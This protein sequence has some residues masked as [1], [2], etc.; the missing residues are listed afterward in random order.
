MRVPPRAVG[1]ALARCWCR[2]GRRVA[3]P[4]GCGTSRIGEGASLG[5]VEEVLFG[6]GGSGPGQGVGARKVKTREGRTRGAESARRYGRA[7]SP[8]APSR[9]TGAAR[10]A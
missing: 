8:A 5:L 2:C 6:G 3:V 10:A 4:R 9:S 1:G 7:L